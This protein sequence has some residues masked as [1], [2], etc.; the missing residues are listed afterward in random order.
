M[1]AAPEPTVFVVDDDKAVRDSLRWLI[2]SVGLNVEIFANSREFLEGYKPARPGCIVLDVRMPGISGMELQEKLASLQVTVPIIFITGHGDVKMAVRAVKA[3]AL[4]FIEK[5][6]ND[7]ELL[8]RVQRAIQLDAENRRAI[9]ERSAI[10]RRLERLTPRER[11]VMELIIEGR[12]NKVIA[13]RL[14]LSSKTVEAHRAKVMEKMQT[15]S[16]SVLV[17]MVL[18]SKRA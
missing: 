10:A 7:Q 3:G 11:E 4:D 17:K 15:K 2:E 14:G 13:A 18:S 6:F 12:L 9:E 16:V 5:P 1:D 8:D